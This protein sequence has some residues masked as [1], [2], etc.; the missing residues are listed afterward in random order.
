MMKR[1]GMTWRVDPAHW[2]SYKQSHLEPWPE[3]IDEIQKA[4]IH[5]YSIYAYGTRVFAYFEVEG[6][7]QEALDRLST[8]EVKKRWDV[9]VTRFVL[10]SADES[11]EV[12]FRE[13]ETIFFC[14]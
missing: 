9:G 2:E 4:G 11:T 12:Q 1:V 7:P 10:P 3:L 5:N 13:L 14:P 8:T 6:D